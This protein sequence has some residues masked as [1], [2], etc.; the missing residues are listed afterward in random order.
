MT[1]L[2]YKKAFNLYH[3]VKIM[4]MKNGRFEFFAHTV[5]ILKNRDV[6]VNVNNIYFL[7]KY[8]TEINPS[9]NTGGRTPLSLQV[10]YKT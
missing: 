8:K 6:N 9:S 10:Q 5:P 2:H 4:T 1:V 3:I 7:H